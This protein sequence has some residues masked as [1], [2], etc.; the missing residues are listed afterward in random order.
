[1]DNVWRQQ[2]SG[3]SNINTQRNFFPFCH[4]RKEEKE[5]EKETKKTRFS[6]RDDI[7]PGYKKKKKKKKR[8]HHSPGYDLFPFNCL[9]ANMGGG[10]GVG[11]EMSKPVLLPRLIC[12]ASTTVFLFL[13]SIA[14]TLSFIQT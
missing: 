12:I 14:T 2:L 3:S 4:I 11:G 13:C 5:E 8:N 6:A 9:Y 7:F 10:V 1:V